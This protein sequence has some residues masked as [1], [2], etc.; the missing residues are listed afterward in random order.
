MFKFKRFRLFSLCCS[1]RYTLSRWWYAPTILFLGNLLM[2]IVSVEVMSVLSNLYGAVSSRNLKLFRSTLVW[3]VVVVTTISVLKAY[4]LYTTESCALSWRTCTLRFIHKHYYLKLSLDTNMDQSMTNLGTIDQRITQDTDRL[5]TLTAKL[6]ADVMILPAV[7]G[8]YTFYLIR[9]FGWEVPFICFG[10]FLCGCTIS[11]FLSRRLVSIV[12]NQE[13]LEGEFRAAHYHYRQ[14][15]S[16][17]RLLRGE[18]CERNDVVKTFGDLLTN[19]EELIRQRMWLNTFT[20]WF[21]YSASIGK[22]VIFV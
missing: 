6:L 10:Y 21:A 17:I 13:G 12:Y 14:H 5:T 9:L 18:I 3:A 19:T 7:I 8:F 22:I 1:T 16:E 20:N 15:I 11:L 2:E 4:V